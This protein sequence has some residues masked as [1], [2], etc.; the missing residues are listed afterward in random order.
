VDELK[1]RGTGE[2]STSNKRNRRVETWPIFLAKQERTG[3]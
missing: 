1:K 3:G 2:G